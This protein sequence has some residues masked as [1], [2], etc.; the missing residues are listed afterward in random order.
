MI[1]YK[2]SEISVFKK[3][4]EFL[5]RFTLAIGLSGKLG[6]FTFRNNATLVKW[7][8]AVETFSVE[9]V[10]KSSFTF[11][12]NKWLNQLRRITLSVR[13]HVVFKSVAS[14]KILWQ[15]LFQAVF[16]KFRSVLR[17]ILNSAR[18]KRLINAFLSSW[19]FLLIHM[20]GE[21][22]IQFWIVSEMP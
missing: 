17:Y 6:I 20:C 3:A 13:R 9:N 22:V 5:I 2:I 10:T 14:S 15:H 12:L 16:I 8:V 7:V 19:C 4:K 1:C 21:G 18:S 11:S